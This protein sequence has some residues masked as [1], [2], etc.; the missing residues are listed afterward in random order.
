MF[1]P[2]SFRIARVVPSCL[3]ALTIGIG[4]APLTVE[5]SSGGA[6]GGVLVNDGAP[7]PDDDAASG[8]APDGGSCGPGDVATYHPTYHAANV[9]IGAC[10]AGQVQSFFDAC[11]GSTKSTSD[12]QDFRT[13]YPTCASC[14]ITPESATTYGPIIDH[15][16]FVSTNVAGCI[17]VTVA[18][19]GTA[20]DAGVAELTCA[21]AVEALAGCELAACEANCAVHDATSL[22]EFSQCT[23]SA[24]GAGCG[25][26]SAAAS[27]VNPESDAAV[28]IPSACV[29]SD[30]AAFYAAIVP[31]FCVAPPPLDAGASSFDAGASSYDADA[32]APPP[33]D[34]AATPD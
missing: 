28:P 20:A 5:S 24:D 11:F 23:R 15:T 33:D 17:E 27:C 10:D 6:D 32:G 7:G 13:K 12:C 8:F 2:P 18:E 14:I 30:F 1:I 25:T 26:F 22:S 3:L 16:G 29:Q 19:V 21:H 9:Q 34:A 31:L 4:C